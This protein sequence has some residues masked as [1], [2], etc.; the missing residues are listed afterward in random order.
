MVVAEASSAEEWELELL[1]PSELRSSGEADEV[2]EDDSALL[3]D[4]YLARNVA[5]ETGRRIVVPGVDGRDDVVVDGGDTT[6]TIIGWPGRCEVHE[7]FTVDDIRNARKQFP[8]VLILAHPECSPEVVEA[9]DFSGS[10]A[11]MIAKVRSSDA[12]RYLLM[13]ECSMGD[14]IAA[15]N[16]EIVKRLRALHQAWVKDVV[17]K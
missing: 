1:Y 6:K 9:S 8:D 5:R 11:A 4:E 12:P 3:P 10:T 7:K 2:G 17:A 14:N 13:T 16:P 15:E